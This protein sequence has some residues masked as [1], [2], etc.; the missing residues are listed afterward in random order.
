MSEPKKKCAMME[1]GLALIFWYFLRWTSTMFVSIAYHS[2]KIGKIFLLI[3]QSSAA[4]SFTG[5]LSPS[6]L[7]C[8]T[9]STITAYLNWQKDKFNFPLMAKTSM[10]WKSISIF[11]FQNLVWDFKLIQM[12]FQEIWVLELLNNYMIWI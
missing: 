5:I 3:C 7:I 12:K 10:S 4:I 8:I 6:L 1:I 11:K 9:I 2:N